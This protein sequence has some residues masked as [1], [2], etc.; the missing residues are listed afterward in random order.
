[1]SKVSI[2]TQFISHYQY[3][4]RIDMTNYE[5]NKAKNEYFSVLQTLENESSFATL[6]DISQKGLKYW[7]PKDV[8]DLKPIYLQFV[9]L[10]N[11]NDWFMPFD[12][13]YRSGELVFLKTLGDLEVFIMSYKKSYHLYLQKHNSVTATLFC[14]ITS[15]ELKDYPVSQM[16]IDIIRDLRIFSVQNNCLKI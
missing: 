6:T 7:T 10:F 1:M 14:E 13:F 15:E 4:E 9:E 2:R 5:L 12:L 11:K 3:N 16:M 8:Q